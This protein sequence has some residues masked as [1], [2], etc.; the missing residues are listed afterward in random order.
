[1]TE[2]EEFPEHW[3]NAYNLINLI[4]EH[5]R[6]SPIG[7]RTLKHFPFSASMIVKR[8]Q[9]IRK[10][11]D[12]KPH[13]Y[14]LPTYINLV[15][16]PCITSTILGGICPEMIPYLIACTGYDKDRLEV[17]INDNP[18]IKAFKEK[19]GLA[20][21]RIKLFSVAGWHDTNM[22]VPVLN[23]AQMSDDDR[24]KA[25]RIF[26]HFDSDSL[27][28][29]MQETLGHY[30]DDYNLGSGKKR[31]MDVNDEVDSCLLKTIINACQS[32]DRPLTLFPDKNYLS[33]GFY[34]GNQKGGMFLVGSHSLRQGQV[35][36][37][38]VEIDEKGIG[39]KELYHS[40][41]T[42]RRLM[43]DLSSSPQSP[44]QGKFVFPLAK[45]E[46]KENKLLDVISD[47]SN[48]YI[49]ATDQVISKLEKVNGQNDRLIAQPVCQGHHYTGITGFE[50][51]RIKY[52]AAGY[53]RGIDIINLNEEE[54]KKIG[55]DQA[56]IGNVN[57]TSGFKCLQMIRTGPMNMDQA[58][59][60]THSQLG[61]IVVP[62][63]KLLEERLIIDG[64]SPLLLVRS[65]SEQQI[66]PQPYPQ[67]NS[68][69][70]RAKVKGDQ[71]YYSIGRKLYS[72]QLT[73]ENKVQLHEYPESITAL[74]AGLSGVYVGTIG[75]KIYH[76]QE[77]V[78]DYC[79]YNS[80]ILNLGGTDI[81]GTPG[82]LFN[83]STK[84][85][86]SRIYFLNV[87]ETEE[88]STQ[89][90]I[91]FK[92]DGQNLFSL[93]KSGHFVIEDLSLKPA[94]RPNLALSYKLSDEPVKSG[95]I[96]INGG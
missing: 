92:N 90:A 30:W 55:I 87:L 57:L 80:S 2:T 45:Q 82:V 51:G 12:E 8:G 15:N 29:F 70:L 14:S 16:E 52:V 24:E 39:Q 32:R 95:C 83:L 27:H 74:E 66:N 59:V 21:Y 41:H 69:P 19:E 96:Y 1:M 25:N 18:K 71:I 79:N 42:L 28:E 26:S 13:L 33:N 47:Q 38:P 91:N 6:Q 86:I 50:V 77:L 81:G 46:N 10:I 61:I 35:W 37:Q 20:D 5:H 84:G 22:M 88:V 11:I 65:S 64:L 49:A 40:V 75:G 3:N 63:E 17:V 85:L 7:I 48:R 72:I 4:A 60:A 68:Q 94:D 78:F 31:Q 62:L 89:Q 73:G 53:S 54:K 23:L 93:T 67:L 58:L 34:Q 44:L 43:E 36:P 76:D 9:E 56:L